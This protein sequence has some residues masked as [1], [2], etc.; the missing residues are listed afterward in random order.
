MNNYQKL[1]NNGDYQQVVD[2]LTALLASDSYNTEA[3]IWLAKAQFK[4]EQFE[5][6]INNYSKLIN[7]LP[8]IADLYSDRGLC[9]HLAGEHD[10]A[11]NDF[12]KAV[13]LEPENAYRYSCRA[14]VKDYYKDYQGALKDYNKAIEIDP[15]DAIT[16]NNKGVLEEKLGFADQA[17]QSFKASNHIQGI[18]L[19]KELANINSSELPAITLSKP[20]IRKLSFYSYL[21]I[22]KSVFTTKKGLKEF[23]GYLTTKKK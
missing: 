13:E 5:E 18:D 10:L 8:S 14:F 6:A 3:L 19:E 9:H 2:E 7:L 23:I 17:Q 21:S 1:I 22:I 20:E 11:L 4:L 15:S 12:D 16:H